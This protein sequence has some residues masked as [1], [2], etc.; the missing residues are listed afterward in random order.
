[1]TAHVDVTREGPLLVLTLSRPE[2]KNALT[3]AMYDAL[4][5]A[6]QDASADERRP[7]RPARRIARRVHRGN[8]IA[9]FLTGRGR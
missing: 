1:M 6:L 3:A 7:R 2:K 5:L 4:C 8:D 9:D